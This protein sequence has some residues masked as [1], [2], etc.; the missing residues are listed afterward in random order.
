MRRH[1]M[2]REAF[3]N[4][5]LW[6]GAGAA[7][8]ALVVMVGVLFGWWTVIA[9]TVVMVGVLAL[10]LHLILRARVA[11]LEDSESPVRA[12]LP[13]VRTVPL[14]PDRPAAARPASCL[15]PVLG[16]A[17][18]AFMFVSNQ[19]SQYKLEEQNKRVAAEEADRQAQAARQREEA[20]QAALQQQ[21]AADEQLQRAGFEYQHG[22]E[23]MAI[24][25]AL[26]FVSE[27]A[28]YPRSMKIGFLT[29]CPMSDGTW[30]VMGDA[31]AKNQFG[32]YVRQYWGCNVQWL[33]DDRWQCL[34]LNTRWPHQ[35]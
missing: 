4:F 2:D 24:Q 9:L 11:A 34:Y 21:Q 10:V 25:M 26:V 15:F 1:G 30:M 31:T 14:G 35:D 3:W 5:L 23:D 7:L 17:V 19:V 32:D 27:A 18:F 28:Y 33:G 6:I 13:P 8:V 12:S 22:S 29:A 20:A 16:L